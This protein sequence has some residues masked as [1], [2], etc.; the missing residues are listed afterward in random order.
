[1]LWVLK[2]P[3]SNLISY[4]KDLSNS[5]F[6]KTHIW[7]C[8]TVQR[9]NGCL[10]AHCQFLFNGKEFKMAFAA[11]PNDFSNSVLKCFHDAS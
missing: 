1:M 4:P 10:G 6:D 9:S 7:L 8:A 3:V 5:N 11:E 2:N